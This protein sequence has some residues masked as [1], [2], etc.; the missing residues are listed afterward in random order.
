MK[1]IQVTLTKKECEVEII[2]LNS[3]FVAKAVE[4]KLA[5]KHATVSLKKVHKDYNTGEEKIVYNTSINSEENARV[6]IEE[7]LPFLEELVD[8]MTGKE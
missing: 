8:A 5:L 4:A 6:I 1:K 7:V 3:Y 2:E